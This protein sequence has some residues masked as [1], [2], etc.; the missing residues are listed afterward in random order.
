[1]P[2]PYDL[3]VKAGSSDGDG[4]QA[5]PFGTIDEAYSV[6]EPDGK[7]TVLSGEYPVN[8]QLT[9]NKQGVTLEARQG[10]TVMLT[11]QVVPFV[12][13]G[14][15]TAI[16][17]FAFTSDVPYPVEFIQ[18][19]ANDVLLADNVIYGP[20]QSGDSSGWVVN[21][22]V[23]TQGGVR[24]F[25]MRNNEIYSLRQAAYFNP[26]SQG[27][28]MFNTVY[29][30]RGYVVDRANVLFSGNSWGLPENAVD[31]ALLAGTQSGAPYDPTT[32]LSQYNSSASLSD[33]R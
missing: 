19:G 7:I 14:Q 5:K 26:S 3:F 4:T 1:M 12:V 25:T 9:M 8:S 24:N 22:G 23:V 27:T 13:T 10:A 15:N 33:Q 20:A 16:K 11:A 18:V 21:R 31:I 30:T 29:N 2:N 28:V 32:S 6:V 17:G